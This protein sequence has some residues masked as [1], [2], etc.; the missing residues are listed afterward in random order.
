MTVD[1]STNGPGVA[2]VQ[3]EEVEI[4]GATR[5]WFDHEPPILIGS[6]LPLL[7]TV[8]IERDAKSTDPTV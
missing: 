1:T 5:R 2:N 7:R 8:G 3:T 6:L 4:G